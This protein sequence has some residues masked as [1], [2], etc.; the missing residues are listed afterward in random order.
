MTNLATSAKFRRRAIA[1]W[2]TTVLLAAELAVGGVRRQPR[3]GHVGPPPH[4]DKPPNN[5][6]Q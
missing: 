5:V 6:I 3:R 2:V 1:Y 4:A